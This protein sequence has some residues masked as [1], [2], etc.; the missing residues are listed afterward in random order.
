L[1]IINHECL[2]YYVDVKIKKFTDNAA[3]RVSEN[4]EL[5]IHFTSVN[6]KIFLLFNIKDGSHEHAQYIKD[7]QYALPITPL[8]KIAKTE[9]GRL[10]LISQNPIY[11]E[12]DTEGVN[13]NT[14]EVGVDLAD[15]EQAG[16]DVELFSELLSDEVTGTCLSLVHPLMKLF[17]YHYENSELRMKHR[18]I[19][20]SIIEA[21]IIFS[22]YMKGNETF[23]NLYVGRQ[24]MLSGF[25]DDYYDYR[26]GFEE[27]FD[28]YSEEYI[29]QFFGYNQE[30][31]EKYM[32][33]IEKLDAMGINTK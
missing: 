8:S 5:C 16:I 14:Y 4:F 25:Q 10:I 28:N 11:T 26:N 30:V 3:E 17:D 15:L 23:K 27:D 6:E 2:D 1:E 33:A 21:T 12:E 7:A 13:Y 22:E 29:L 9:N 19:L 32:G 20:D 18:K 31:I 24:A